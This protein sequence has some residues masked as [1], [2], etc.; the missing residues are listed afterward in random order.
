MIKIIFEMAN[1][2]Q[3]SLEHGINI[4]RQYSEIK[5]KFKN[6]FEFYFKLQFRDMKTFISPKAIKENKNKHIPRFLNTKLSDNQFDLLIKEIKKQKFKL[7]ITPFD[8]KSVSK[9]V[10]KV[11]YIKIASCSS[12]DWPLLERIASTKKPVICSLGSRTYD[13]IDNLY[14]F[15]S[16]R[17]SDLSFLHCVGIYPTPNKNMN[18]VTIKKLIKR[19]NQVN[20]GYSGHELPDDLS[21]SILALSLGSKIFERHVGLETE[22]VSLNKYSMNPNQTL[23]WLNSLKKANI[24]LGNSKRII[25]KNEQKSLN[26]LARGVFAKKN[27]NKGD[28]LSKSNTYFAFPKKVNQ[29]SSGNFKDNIIASINYKKNDAIVEKIKNADLLIIRKYIKRYK[30]FFIESGIILPKINYNIELSY[31]YGISK[32]AKYGA[33]LINIVNRDFCKKY[34]ILLPGQ[35]HPLQKHVVKEEYFTVLKGQADVTKNNIHYKLNVGD[36][37]LIE[38]NEWHEFSSNQGVILEELSTTS[39]RNDSFYKDPKIAKKDPLE[40]K[41]L[42][43]NW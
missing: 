8:E 4:I 15:F 33:C 29:V 10:N 18:I 9:I 20:I 6:N 43:E 39:L 27:I 16:K 31:H 12:N 17:V 35:A 30:H 36:C 42:L 37:L 22:H 5:N 32:I 40:R 34:I 3:G 28:K 38:R 19:Y 26:D 24:Q 13:E 25:S 11:D 21:P 7:I 2:H 41:T 23:N 1:N 14:S